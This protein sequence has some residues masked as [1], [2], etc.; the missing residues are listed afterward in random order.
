ML[1]AVLVGRIC[2][3]GFREHSHITGS[4]T[5]RNQLVNIYMILMLRGFSVGSIIPTVSEENPIDA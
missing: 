5:N 3:S 2:I 1:S 4:R